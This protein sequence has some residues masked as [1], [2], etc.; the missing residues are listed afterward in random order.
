MKRPAAS[1][2]R[3]L[4]AGNPN[5]G[6]SSLF[7]A[8]T[9]AHQHTGNWT[10]KTVEGAVGRYRAENGVQVVSGMARGI[11]GIAGREALRERGVLRYCYDYRREV[12]SD[13][14]DVPRC[15]QAGTLSQA[16]CGG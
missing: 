6:K 2:R 5:V 13:Q 8:L 9:G 10:G 14:E 7:N 11:D 15:W 12:P 1:T 4:L 3:V 16:N